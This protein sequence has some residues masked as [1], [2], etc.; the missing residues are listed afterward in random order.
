MAGF[1]S[2]DLSAQPASP[3][4]QK[5]NYLRIHAVNVFVRDQEKSLRFY[6]D[7]LG[8][9]LAFDVFLQS[10]ERWLGVSPPDGTAVLTLIAPDPE[11]E[12]Y[13]LIGQPTSLVFVAED[14][15][16]TYTEWR[17]RGVRF[18]HTP[19]LRRIKPQQ[20]LTDARPD[21]ILLGKQTPIWGGVF[22]RFEDID[23][24]SFALVSFDEMTEAMERQ[25]RANAEKLELERRSAHELFIAK[26]VQAR[27][28]PQTTP[29]LKTLDYSG[30]CIQARQ[31]GGDYYDFLNLGRD[32]VGLV[33]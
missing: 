14:V 4:R 1:S 28:F 15:V 10:G 26:Q 24:N 13:K 2:I 11:S 6:L 16:A 32:R 23:R 8:F 25:R 17:S 19:R 27:L 12:A 30:I 33:L 31:V 21:S 18:R 3:D 5:T 9:T 29:Q 7:Q 20:S 22:T